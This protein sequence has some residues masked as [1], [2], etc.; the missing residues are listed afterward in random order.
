MVSKRATTKRLRGSDEYETGF[1]GFACIA[2]QLC[3]GLSLRSNVV[4]SSRFA[5]GK[6]GINPRIKPEKSCKKKKNAERVSALIESDSD[7]LLISDDTKSFVDKNVNSSDPF[8][9]R[10]VINSTRLS[11]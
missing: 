6:V 11:R 7:D 9:T 3:A 8:D 4:P 2:R 1:V 10:V 5:L